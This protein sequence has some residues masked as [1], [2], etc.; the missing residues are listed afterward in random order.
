MTVVTSGH[1]DWQP[2]GSVPTGSVVR[3]TTFLAANSGFHDVAT[4]DVTGFGSLIIKVVG[5]TTAYYRVWLSWRDVDDFIIRED[6][7][8]LTAIGQVVFAVPV[9]AP[10]V[11]LR[12]EATDFDQTVVWSIYP[13]ASTLPSRRVTPAAHVIFTQRSVV[14]NSRYLEEFVVDPGIYVVTFTQVSTVT[15]RIFGYVES[16]WATS[17]EVADQPAD[18]DSWQTGIRPMRLQVNHP[19]GILRVVLSNETGNVL[20][21]QASVFGS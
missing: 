10:K 5:Q 11:V 12:L 2:P 16:R 17:T 14:P 18:F 15:G 3:G 19:G 9:T 8:F 21:I 4:L 13:I 7:Q 20:L 6:R 1:P